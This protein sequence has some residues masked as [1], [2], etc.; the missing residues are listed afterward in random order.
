MVLN[1]EFKIFTIN[2]FLDK[3]L[4]WVILSETS[5]SLPEMLQVQFQYQEAAAVLTR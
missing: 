5:L 1:V 2:L 4:C 3:L